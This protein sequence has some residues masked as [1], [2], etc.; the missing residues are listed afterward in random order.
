MSTHPRRRLALAI[1]LGALLTLGATDPAPGPPSRRASCS[2]AATA[3]SPTTSAGTRWCRAPPRSTSAGGPSAAPCRR[4]SSPTTT[5]CRPP[6]SARPASPSCSSR[7]TPRRRHDAQ[8][9]R[10]DLRPPRPAARQRGDPHLHRHRHHRGERRRAGSRARRRSSRSAWPRTA[11]PASS[12][13]PGDAALAKDRS[14]RRLRHRRAE[15][16]PW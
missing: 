4:P 7:A 2:T 14:H 13:P 1:T 9:R 16:E 15:I 3:G 6:A 10:R 5:R 11:G 12:P 8:Q